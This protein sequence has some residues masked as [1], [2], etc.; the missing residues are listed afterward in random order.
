MPSH[1]KP[2]MDMSLRKEYMEIPNEPEAYLTILAIRCD[3]AS[4]MLV[5][6]HVT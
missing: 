5:L 4:G 3:L 1:V 2:R 6:A